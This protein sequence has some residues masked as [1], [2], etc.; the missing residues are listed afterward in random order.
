MWTKQV[1]PNQT[2]VTYVL[3]MPNLQIDLAGKVGFNE[4]FAAIRMPFKKAPTT[5]A[6]Y[7][8]TPGQAKSLAH[9]YACE[10]LEGHIE[11]TKAMVDAVRQDLA[12]ANYDE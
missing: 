12:K 11:K 7:A 4:W 1:A 2:D 5:H 8:D 3:K 6:F 10:T 9:R